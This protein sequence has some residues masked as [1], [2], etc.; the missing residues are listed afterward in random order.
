VRTAALKSRN[1][2]TGRPAT[3]P[4]KSIGLE[5][6]ATFTALSICT[7]EKGIMTDALLLFSFGLSCFCLIAAAQNRTAPAQAVG[8]SALRR[9]Q[10]INAA[11]GPELR[12]CGPTSHGSKWRYQGASA[13]ET[14]AGAAPDL[15]ELPKDL[16]LRTD[17]PLTPT[18]QEAVRVS[19]KVA[20]GTAT[21]AWRRRSRVTRSTT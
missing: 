18:A 12:F 21:A 19:E 16:H 8:L 14:P 3:A 6:L 7:S 2:S 4:M 1:S 5:P 10:G 17:V 9:N 20:W 13:A 11:V 15:K